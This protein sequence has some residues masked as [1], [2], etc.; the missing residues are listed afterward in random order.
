MND[1]VIPPTLKTFLSMVVSLKPTSPSDHVEQLIYFIGQDL[2]TA[3]S[4]GEWK[5]PK[6]ILLCM[7]LRHLH[8]S[9]QLLVLL[10]KLG[11]CETYMFSVEL[12]IAV[13]AAPEQTSTL[14]TSRILT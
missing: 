1:R 14:L 11:H 13:A 10:N 12:E 9:K 2:C 8:R 3:V 7:T 5:L 6:Y 4:N